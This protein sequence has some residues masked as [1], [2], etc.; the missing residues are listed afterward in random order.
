MLQTYNMLK[1][2]FSGFFLACQDTLD[3]SDPPPPKND[4]TC[5]N[6]YAIKRILPLHMVNAI[7]LSRHL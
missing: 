3:E 2:F 1:G 4:V 5:L 6:K 7:S